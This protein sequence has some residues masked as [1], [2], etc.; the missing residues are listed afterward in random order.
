[1]AADDFEGR[2]Q[3]DPSVWSSPA[4]P[5][6]SQPATM[7]DNFNMYNNPD[8]F[9]QR[10]FSQPFNNF[11]T[12]SPN[13]QQQQHGNAMGNMNRQRMVRKHFKIL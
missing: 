4:K 6:L 13:Q 7:I 8:L 9:I 11:L 12:Q 10:N 5:M 3:L 1:M 2:L